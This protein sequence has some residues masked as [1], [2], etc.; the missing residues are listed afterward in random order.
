MNMKTIESLI[1][2]KTKNL[3]VISIENNKANIVYLDRKYANLPVSYMDSCN[4]WCIDLPNGDAV[5]I[6]ND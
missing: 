1:G 5:M 4:Y 3:H 6:K 2:L